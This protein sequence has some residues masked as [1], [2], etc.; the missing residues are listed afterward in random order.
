MAICLLIFLI[1]GAVWSIGII[2]SAAKLGLICF[3][4]WFV[5]KSLSDMFR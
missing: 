3:G 2:L 4:A 1:F 5:W